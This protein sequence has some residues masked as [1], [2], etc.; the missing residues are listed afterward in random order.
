M[1]VNA[2]ALRG[3]WLFGGRF[4][5]GGEKWKRGV[6]TKGPLENGDGA[7]GDITLEIAVGSGR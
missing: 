4:V 1:P 5:V 6:G 7:G 3:V 2:V